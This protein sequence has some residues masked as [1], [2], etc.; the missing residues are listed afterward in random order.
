MPVTHR[1]ARQ[2]L[3]HL[4]TQPVL[5][6]ANFQITGELAKLG[7]WNPRVWETEVYLVTGSIAA[8]G[9]YLHHI[10]IPRVSLVQLVDLFSGHHTRL[11][12]ILRHEWAHAVAD[13]GPGLT[14]SKRFHETFGGPY[15][16]HQKLFN[17]D[18]AHH[19]TRYAAAMPCEDYAE[20]FHLY[21]KHKAR[22]PW[23]LARKPVIIQKWKFIDDMA[24]RLSA[25]RYRW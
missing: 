4:I 1:S 8:Y 18:P 12:D 25:N 17:Y 2:P 14:R 19:V 16:Q 21:M 11:P 23:H 3:R 5:N 22:I 13:A 9:W 7:F 24:R 20:T 10:Y 6:Q 15:D